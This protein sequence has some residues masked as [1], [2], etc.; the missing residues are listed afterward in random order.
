M[1]Q[2]VLLSI[3]KG[4]LKT[5]CYIIFFI[6]KGHFFPP[7]P[8][9]QKARGAAAPPTH[10]VP[11]SLILVIPC[12]IKMHSFL[13]CPSNPWPEC[14]ISV[15]AN[16]DLSI[17]KAFII[18]IVSYSAMHLSEMFCSLHSHWAHWDRKFDSHHDQTYF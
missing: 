10:P 5:Y 12:L 15:T 6:L 3:T 8:S 11:A 14:A 2:R 18:L 17:L 9:Q 1:P 13:I 7:C 4:T 16:A